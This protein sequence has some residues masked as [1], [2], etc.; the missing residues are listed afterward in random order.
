MFLHLIFLKPIHLLKLNY[1][2]CIR[3]LLV[4]SSE[5]QVILTEEINHSLVQPHTQNRDFIKKA[6]QDLVTLTIS[7]V[8]HY[9]HCGKL[10]PLFHSTYCICLLIPKQNFFTAILFALSSFITV[11]HLYK[12]PGSRYPLMRQLKTAV[13]LLP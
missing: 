2:F 3:Y 11:H 13:T 7:K 10:I 1:T 9:D 6:A 12:E 4:S 8:R 5:S